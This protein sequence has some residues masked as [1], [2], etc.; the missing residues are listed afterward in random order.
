MTT[1]DKGEI[2]NV[3]KAF[4]LATDRA[5]PREMAALMCAD[6]A[7]T[8]LDNVADPDV[9]EPACLESEPVQS[10][11]IR[12]F[13]DI[14]LARITRPSFSKDSVIVCR[15]EDGRWTVCADAEDDLSLEQLEEDPHAALEHAPAERRRL[16]ELRRT[17]IGRLSIAD[18]CDLLKHDEGLEYLLPRATIKLQ[19]EPLLAGDSRPGDLMIAALG[20]DNAQWSKD[21]VSLFRIQSAIRKLREM[22][23]LDPQEAPDDELIDKIATFQAENPQ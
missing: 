23:D 12:V 5:V 3:V 19:W 22:G 14:A 1:G 21:P 9:A 13:D 7:E 15:R 17:P 10:L 2:D 11:D 20:I 18:I 8:F 4:A 6:E 16:Q